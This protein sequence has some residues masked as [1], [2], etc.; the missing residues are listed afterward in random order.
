VQNPQTFYR[1][2]RIAF[3]VHIVR[4]TDAAVSGMG[5]LRC[6]VLFRRN[7]SLSQFQYFLCATLPTHSLHISIVPERCSR[8]EER[9]EKKNSEKAGAI[10]QL[11]VPIS[12]ELGI[13][14]AEASKMVI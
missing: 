11:E 5:F 6:R 9:Q 3:P 1:R 8:L 13:H 12:E 14:A 2:R 10:R 7:I 4:A